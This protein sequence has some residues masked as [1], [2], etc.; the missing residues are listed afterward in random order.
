MT[1]ILLSAGPVNTHRQLIRLG[2]KPMR[3][4][5][6]QQ[7]VIAATHLQAANLGTLVTLH[8]GVS[9]FCSVFIKKVPE[10]AQMVLDMNNDL[11]SV[12]KYTERY[13]L[14]LPAC[15]GRNIKDKLIYLGYLSEAHFK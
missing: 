12:E 1:S 8:G 15:I 14:L 13:R 5:T 4:L 7:Y 9:R 2:P 10:E 6:K 3:S 11:C